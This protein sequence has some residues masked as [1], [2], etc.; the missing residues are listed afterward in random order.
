MVGNNQKTIAR[1]M[2][3]PFFSGNGIDSAVICTNVQALNAVVAVVEG[4][5]D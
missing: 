3:T 1:Q 2:L 5:L 4:A